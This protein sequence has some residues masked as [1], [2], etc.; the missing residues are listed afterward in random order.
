LAAATIAS[1]MPV[2]PEVGSMMTVFG[3]SS[4]ASLGVLD[5]RQPD[6]VLDAAAGIGPFQLHPDFDACDRQNN[7]LMRTWGVLPIVSRIV[8]ALS[9]DLLQPGTAR[10][11]NSSI[12]AGR[13]GATP[14]WPVKLVSAY[15]VKHSRRRINK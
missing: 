1:A 6:A 14:G 8:Y 4:A 2:L 10:S 15:C 5:H 12:P 7:R 9:W 3:L 11:K 13:N